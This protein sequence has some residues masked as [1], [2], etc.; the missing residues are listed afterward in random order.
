MGQV[1]FEN[2]D[3][4]VKVKGP[5]GQSIFSLS[6]VSLF[7]FF[8]QFGPGQIFGS[9]RVKL[10]RL[11]KRVRPVEDDVIGDVTLSVWCVQRACSVAGACKHVNRPRRLPVPLVARGSAL[12]HFWSQNFW[13]L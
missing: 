1:R 12:Q 10:G 9:V 2:F 8:R 3:F 11:D 13:A 6:F 4:L 7:F 5:I